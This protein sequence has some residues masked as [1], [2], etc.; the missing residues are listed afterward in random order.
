MIESPWSSRGFLHGRIGEV[1][2]CAKLSRRFSVFGLTSAEV[3]RQS[4][5]CCRVAT[6]KILTECNF[7]V[8]SA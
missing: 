4:V 1:S 7:C 5:L 6:L 3:I 8:L 2:R